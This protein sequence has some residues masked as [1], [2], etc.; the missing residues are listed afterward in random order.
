MVF[1]NIVDC[2]AAARDVDAHC[3]CNGIICDGSRYTAARSFVHFVK[4]ARAMQSLVT[5][6]PA[7]WNLLLRVQ[8]QDYLYLPNSLL[9]SFA[10]KDRSS[11]FPYCDNKDLA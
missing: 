3:A 6:C 2:V 11:S 7:N 1:E 5:V 8:F 10:N 9:T 4:P